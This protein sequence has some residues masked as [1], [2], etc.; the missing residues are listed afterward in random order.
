MSPNEDKWSSCAQSLSS[1]FLPVLHSSIPR[2]GQVRRA[3]V[4]GPVYQP[5]PV[6]PC[7][8]PASNLHSM[9]PPSPFK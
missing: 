6:A 7:G 2:H 8:G 9:K 3:H 5:I 1:P 4:M